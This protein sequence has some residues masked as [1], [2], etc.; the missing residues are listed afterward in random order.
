MAVMESFNIPDM[1]DESCDWDRSR[2]N[3]GP[4]QLA[5]AVCGTMFTANKKKALHGVRDFY[6]TSSVDTL[7]GADDHRSLNDMAIGRML[8]TIYDADPT[9]MFFDIS[10]KV[11]AKLCLNSR[12]LHL[13]ASNVTI[14]K[15]PWMVEDGEEGSVPCPRFGHPKDRRTDKLQYNFQSMVDE[16]GMLGYMRLHDGN[17]T[18]GEM[19]MDA[20]KFLAK[21]I[22]HRNI[23]AV[24][25]CKIMY[26]EMVDRLI[27][28]NI[29]FVSK[30]PGNFAKNIKGSIIETALEH[31]FEYVGRIGKR[32][33]A[34]EYEA[35]DMPL[36]V[37]GDKLRF[38][39]Y[40][41]IGGKN[42]YEYYTTTG[43]KHM[44]K[45]FRRFTRKR[46]TRADY[47]ER[48]FLGARAEV[49]DMP[50]R[51]EY[52]IEEIQTQE[53]RQHGGRPFKNENP[54]TGSIHYKVRC[55][56]TFD[57]D[58]ADELIKRRDVQLIVTTI[59]FSDVSCDDVSEGAT[60][61]DVMRIYF[62]QWRIEHVFGEMKSGLGA[63]S[64]FVR[65]GKR[66]SAMLFLIA[67]A[68]L[69][70]SVI[71][72]ILRRNGGGCTCIPKDITARR[73]FEMLQN[74]DM[75]YDRQRDTVGL[76]GPPKGQTVLLT[77]ADL[78]CVD[79]ASLLG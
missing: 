79:P 70:R 1:I 75:V 39:A 58:L 65:D 46:F 77:A 62:G 27:W 59:P 73:L 34:P 56:W 26:A 25:D 45:C 18:D 67:M 3:I 38:I 66:E 15:D 2:R 33:D 23:V 72:F 71:R 49:G 19:S 21:K 60:T 13:D 78:L 51:V 50:Y 8:D 61:E 43:A 57:Q 32:A 76:D 48:A 30:C 31:E 47:A 74:T 44:E 14:S 28:E 53:K 17:R 29:P 55:S 42:T 68:V 36:Y 40:R 16:F 4:G 54:P 41:T 69:V 20:L 11:R 64:V 9:E 37:N 5:K 24:A 12:F 10:S 63:D 7:F 6:E 22:E 35:Y 52:S